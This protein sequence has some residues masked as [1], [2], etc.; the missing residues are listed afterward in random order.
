MEKTMRDT[1]QHI[2]ILFSHVS[3]LIRDH[4]NNELNKYDLHLGQSRIMNAL[5]RQGTLNQVDLAKGLHIKP[6]T[7]TNMV[8]KLEKKGFITRIQ[9][10]NDNRSLRISLTAKGHKAAKHI[11]DIWNRIESEVQAVIPEDENE[12][13]HFLLKKMRDSF[14]GKGPEI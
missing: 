12:K 2:W 5:R 4:A 14:G 10:K 9:S 3:K 11:Q 7:V 1:K 13:V 6:A 8:Q